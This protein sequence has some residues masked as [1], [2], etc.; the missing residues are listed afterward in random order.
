[1]LRL[2]GKGDLLLEK[3]ALKRKAPLFEK[4]FERTIKVRDGGE[5]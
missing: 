5:D 2:E 3:W 1:V 4:V